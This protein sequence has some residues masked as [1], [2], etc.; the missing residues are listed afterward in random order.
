VAFGTGTSNSNRFGNRTEIIYTNTPVPYTWN[1]AFHEGIDRF[2]V[3]NGLEDA[4][5][6]RLEI[7]SRA[8]TN[9]F[10]TQHSSFIVS[11]AG[12]KDIA[13]TDYTPLSVAT[14]F[15]SLYAYFLNIQAMGTKI[16]KVSAAVSR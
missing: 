9:K 4:V 6:D 15:N 10:N 11:A 1:W 2:T 7:Q 14:A 13:L 8:M 3:N 12:K 5:A 16:A